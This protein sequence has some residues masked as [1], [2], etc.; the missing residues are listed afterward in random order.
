MLFKI[1]IYIKQKATFG[2]CHIVLIRMSEVVGWLSEVV[3]NGL[4]P[5]TGCV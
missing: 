1:I 2:G 5:L 4:E 3:A